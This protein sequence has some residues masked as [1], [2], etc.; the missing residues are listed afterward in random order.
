MQIVFGNELINNA[1]KNVKI[2]KENIPSNEILRSK[3]IEDSSNIKNLNIDFIEEFKN[4]LN[5]VSAAIKVNIIEDFKK[6]ILAI[7]INKDEEERKRIDEVINDS[8]ALYE[9]MQN[10]KDFL[11]EQ[12]KIKKEI[13]NRIKEID[14][15][16]SDAEILKIEYEKYNKELSNEDKIF[17]PSK[18]ANMLINQRRKLLIKIDEINKMMTPME[19]VKKEEEL[20]NKNEFF[21]DIKQDVSVLLENL[22]KD[23]I[24]LLNERLEKTED[25]KE[26]IDIIYNLRYYK[27]IPYNDRK[28]CEIDALKESIKQLE[29]SIIK[30]ACN[31]KILVKISD[32]EELNY[33]ILKYIFKSKIINLEDI[34]IELKYNK[35]ILSVEYFD[36][37][38]IEDTCDIKIKT[39]TEL[40]VRL[41]KKIKLFI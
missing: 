27:Y 4:S 40:S 14:N 39:K 35:D 20:K 15:I 6:V 22:Q 34:V 7:I 19:F 3:Y 28:I 32:D 16:I 37:D 17:S 23:F 41:K 33:E 18:Y 24:N 9:K 8:K 2:I 30:K 12:T 5:K 29:K 31:K 21:S 25:K 11:A 13:S 26:I 36:S 10:K 38:I 1:Y